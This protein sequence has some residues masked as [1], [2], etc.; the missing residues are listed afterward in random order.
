[1]STDQDTLIKRLC[2]TSDL[3]EIDGKLNKA[4]YLDQHYA[5]DE[6]LSKTQSCKA[7]GI[8][9]KQLRQRTWSILCG[10]TIHDQ[11]KTTYLAPRY[12]A[13]LCEIITKAEISHKSMI[14]DEILDQ[15]VYLNFTH[16]MDDYNS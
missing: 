9:R 16:I 6:E 5:G 2:G 4:V 15:V 10:H 8:S 1:M 14:P 3:R 7:F 11:H 12:E 13:E